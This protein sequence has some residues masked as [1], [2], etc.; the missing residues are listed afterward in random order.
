LSDFLLVIFTFNA[1]ATAMATMA[2]PPN[3]FCL[4]TINDLI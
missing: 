4:M 1:T 3:F 2:I